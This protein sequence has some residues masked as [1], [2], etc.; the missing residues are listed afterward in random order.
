MVLSFLAC[1]FNPWVLRDLANVIAEFCQ[2]QSSRDCGDET[3][4]L[5][6]DPGKC[7]VCKQCKRG[8]SGNHRMTGHLD[9][10]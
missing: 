1:N 7:P 2:Q 6:L 3:D 8:N 9:S 5:R 4:V 10:G